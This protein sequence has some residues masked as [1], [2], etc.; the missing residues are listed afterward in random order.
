MTAKINANR[1][2][3]VPISGG[4]FLAETGPVVITER[5]FKFGEGATEDTA[6]Q[7]ARGLRR[8]RGI[9][10][11]L[12]DLLIA[13]ED[14]FSEIYSQLEHETGFEYSTLTNAK[15][16]CKRFPEALRLW[17]LSPSF[18]EVVAP[19][20][21]P[22]AKKYLDM[23]VQKSFARD[24]FRDYVRE[25]RMEAQ[26]K[27]NKAAGIG[28]GTTD[29]GSEGIGRGKP[30]PV[31]VEPSPKALAVVALDHFTQEERGEL[32]SLVLA[33]TTADQTNVKAYDLAIADQFP[34]GMLM[35]A[36]ERR[37][38]KFDQDETF[39]KGSGPALLKALKAAGKLAEKWET[40][41]DWSEA[42]KPAAKA[43]AKPAG[44]AAAPAAGKDAGKASPAPKPAGKGK[45]KGKAADP[46]PP[47]DG[48]DDLPVRDLSEG[49]A[50]AAA[51][52][53]GTGKAEAVEQA[54]ETG[55]GESLPG[56]PPGYKPEEVAPDLESGSPEFLEYMNAE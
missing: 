56:F 38:A 26:R 49:D 9:N 6:M 21:D 47:V 35:F 30:A 23:A 14:R 16:L 3:L 15:A 42:S 11:I 25:E 18:Y 7:A 17:D 36:I 44:K 33:N 52:E 46:A 22:T 32:A 8:V 27:A 29:N 51:L 54:A 1:G 31:K 2:E 10:W 24:D 48:G 4:G 5:S 55:E 37:V 41:S 50:D 40:E 20:D 39:A 19:C 12:G 53:A 45:E 28:T 34:V 13:C 43:P